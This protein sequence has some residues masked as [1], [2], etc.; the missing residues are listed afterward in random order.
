MGAESLVNRVLSQ[1]Q[2]ALSARLP[3][4]VPETHTHTGSPYARTRAQT[5]ARPPPPRSRATPTPAR[6]AFHT[7]SCVRTHSLTLTHARFSCLHTHIHTP[8]A[9]HMP[10]HT[11]T[12]APKPSGPCSPE[13]LLHSA[14]GPGSGSGEASGSSKRHLALL[15][16]SLSFG[17]WKTPNI[18][19]RENRRFI[20][21]RAQNTASQ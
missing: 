1:R 8:I 18:P 19:T 4:G 14:R 5:R 21:S 9:F 13:Q 12:G 16:F 3:T 7:R 10:V 20:T 15:P 11:L 6:I 17:A 2:P